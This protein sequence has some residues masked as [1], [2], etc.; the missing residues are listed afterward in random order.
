MRSSFTIF[1][2]GLVLGSTLG[3]G[4]VWT[5]VVQ[6]AGEQ[7]QKLE[8]E[9]GIMQTALD[10]A[11]KALKDVAT[12]LRE[13]SSGP[14]PMSTGE[15]FPRSGGSSINPSGLTGEQPSTEVTPLKSADRT[16]IADR[17]DKLALK[18]DAAKTGKSFER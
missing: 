11:G 16:E 18:L 14:A 2:L 12:N 15:I 17:L 8:T 3:I 9:H 7:F 5:Q 6:P 10:E 13:E 4:G 1:L